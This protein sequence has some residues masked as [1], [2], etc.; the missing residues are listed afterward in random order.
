MG[1]FDRFEKGVNNAVAGAFRAFHSRLKPVEITSALKK[2]VD[3]DAVELDRDRTIA[4][5]IYTVK[6]SP[7]DTDLLESWGRDAFTAEL[8]ATLTTYATEQGYVFVGPVEINFASDEALRAGNVTVTSTTRK[9]PV[10]PA[11]TAEPTT[12]HP[13][14]QVDKD[15]YILT[16]ASTVIGRGSDCDITVEDSGISRHHLRLDVTPNGVILTDLGSTNGTFVEGHRVSAA[17]L[18]DGNTITAGRTRILF[19]TGEERA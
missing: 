6:L 8:A 19:W 3:R 5:N 12:A 16:G 1:A 18:V 10:A 7:E 11:T 9:G 17:T 14:I 13:M 2:A 4:T 15:H